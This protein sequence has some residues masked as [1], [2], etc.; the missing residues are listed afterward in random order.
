MIKFSN[1]LKEVKIALPNR[2]WDFTKYNPNFDYNKIKREDILLKKD[3]DG[4]LF[5]FVVKDI[6]ING[7]LL[8]VNNNEKL[9][10]LMSED[11]INKWNEKIK[12][13]EVKISLPHK[14]HN[15]DK[16]GVKF[17]NIKV[18]DILQ[19]TLYS[20]TI[21]IVQQKVIS[22]S[23][24]NKYMKAVDLD[25]KGKIIPNTLI[26]LWTKS[27]LE[28]YYEHNRPLNEY[29][30]KVINT[31]I[32]RWKQENPSI[33]DN[34]KLKQLIQRFEQVKNG[35]NDEKIQIL[36]LSD[37]LKKNKNYLDINNYSFE[38]M[39]K[40][41]RSIP[42]S[43]EKIKKE[44]ITKFINRD[45]VDKN[46]AQSYTARFMR[47][48]D[49]LKYA[50]QNGTEDGTYSKEEV[51]RLI[52][53]QLLNNDIYLDPR[54]WRWQAFEQMLD[55]LYPSQKKSSVDDENNATTD[56]DKIY[57]K[58]NIEIYRGDDVHKCISYNPVISTGRKKYGWCVTQVGNTN[59]DY[60]RFGQEGPTFYFVF[61]RN[62]PST[63]DH[64]PF[65]DVWHAFVIQVNNDN[66]SY[67]I[68]NANNSG[69]ISSPSW[70]GISKI[71]PPETWN[72]IKNLKE[73]FKSIPLSAVER[74]RKFVS[75]KN[76]SL[77]EFKELTQDEKILYIQ[78]KASKNNISKDI[79]SILPKYKINVGGRTTTLANVAID[80]G[81]AFSYELLKDY[82][83][84]AKRYAIFRFRHTN[85][86]KS[87]IPLPFIKYLDEPAKEKYLN[88]FEDNLSFE[89]IE[90]YFGE[91]TLKSTVNQQAKKL[92][93]IP[94]NFIKYIDDSKLKTIYNVYSK[95]Y[96][97]WVGGSNYNNDEAILNS[98]VM[99]EQIVSP[100]LITYDQWLELSPNEKD[101]ILKLIEK[102]DNKE[103]YST[104]LYAAPYILT[105][106][107]NVYFLL[108]TKIEDNM[109]S[110]WVL[111]D[112]N[113][114]II[115][116]NINGEESS[117][118]DDYLISGFPSSDYKRIHSMDDVN[119][120]TNDI[121]EISELYE[122]WDKYQ[123]MVK[124]GILK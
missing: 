6:D 23:E 82:E 86:G 101:L 43:V 100:E 87:P 1:I 108:P 17:E 117:I 88:T 56:A 29:S 69:D 114:K 85:Y 123:L 15:L 72:R 61:D 66:N 55:A 68:T 70:E 2:T 20:P 34:D 109:Y 16:P 116:K 79:L 12:L 42:E 102:N 53:K 22:F 27:S 24:G 37:E 7:M 90:K 91:N 46:T 75:G 36:A 26:D 57:D 112:K 51:Q 120:V 122:E 115:K 59:Y 121:N 84:L 39:N 9:S 93:W 124:A 89:L 47:V 25:K 54:N 18:G 63:P 71:V 92:G 95:L 45:E 11:D 62:K 104:L 73:Y 31:T 67:I 64:S 76:L 49:N 52:P 83:A 60:Y 35:L 96:A 44:A 5:R 40:L 33:K 105:D 113:N 10:L 58:D 98:E 48:K 94:S 80:S 65:T 103:E 21:D 50:V 81:Q 78:G 32:E 19:F 28:H 118:G 106:G 38:D 14:I 99:P 111:L 4:K 30:D 110:N 74:G 8:Y 13:K 107:S 3:R 119:L 97:N 77:D 41:I